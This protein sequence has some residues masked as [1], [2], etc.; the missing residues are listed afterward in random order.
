[1]AHELDAAAAEVRRSDPDR[2]FSALFAPATLRASLVAIYAFNQDLAKVAESVREPMMAEIRYAWWSEAIDAL[3]SG[4]GRVPGPAQAIGEVIGRHAL[5]RTIFE[6][7]IEARRVHDIGETPIESWAA[8]ESYA[9]RTA[10][11]VIKLAARVLGVEADGAAM[12]AGRAWALTG[13]LRS[14]P[15]NLARH[16]LFV[17][18]EMF[19]A[20]H[21]TTDDIFHAKNTAVWRPAISDGVALARVYLTSFR[22][23]WRALPRAAFPAFGYLALCDLYLRGIASAAADGSVTEIGAHRRIPRLV[24]A[25]AT[26]RI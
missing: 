4:S 5:P 25:S 7:M 13:H 17:P 6:D 24:I 22:K 8:F 14:L 20:H 23:Q 26:G 3:F 2:F 9:D 16:K 19:A 18:A 12:P 1:M 11:A 15:L 10:G 21:L